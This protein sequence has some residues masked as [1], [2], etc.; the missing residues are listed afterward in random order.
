MEELKKE[1]HDAGKLYEKGFKWMRFVS[2]FMVVNLIFTVALVA[3][4]LVA[5]QIQETFQWV[6]FGVYGLTVLYLIFMREVVF[7][8]TYG[9][10]VI[11]MRTVWNFSFIASAFGAVNMFV[12]NTHWTLF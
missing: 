1:N 3:V 11:W 7:R 5:P 12:G 10:L 9:S 4:V 2:I 6:A 8:K